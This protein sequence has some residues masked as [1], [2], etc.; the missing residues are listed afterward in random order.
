MKNVRL[1]LAETKNILNDFKNRIIPDEDAILTPKLEPAAKQTPK[2]E[3][4]SA[5]AQVL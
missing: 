1:F 3:P 2:P 4:V 5:P